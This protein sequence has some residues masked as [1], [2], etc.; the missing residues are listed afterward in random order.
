MLSRVKVSEGGLGMRWDRSVVEARRKTK[1]RAS[2]ILR[3]LDAKREQMAQQSR[4]IINGR[5]ITCLSAP[6][7]HEF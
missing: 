5:F 3:S 4:E 7:C 2:V 6:V 1:G